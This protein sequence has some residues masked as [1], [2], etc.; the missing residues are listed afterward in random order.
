MH[1]LPIW[2][3]YNSQ[4]SPVHFSHAHPKAN[5]AICLKTLF[6]R[7]INGPLNPFI[8]NLSAVGPTPHG[9][10]ILRELHAAILQEC[11]QKARAE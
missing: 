2:K 5:S 7:I 8:P 3:H 4:I 9:E 1:R 10:E 11:S 6:N